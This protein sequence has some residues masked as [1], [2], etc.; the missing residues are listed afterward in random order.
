LIRDLGPGEEDLTAAQLIIIDRV[1]TK[2]GV[3]RCIEEHVRETSVMRGNDLAPALQKNYLAYNNS[4]RLD[5][6]ALGIETRQAREDLDL[7]RYVQAKDAE[8]LDREAKVGAERALAASA[9]GPEYAGKGIHLGE[10]AI[11][12]GEGEKR[13]S[14]MPAERRS[15][16]GEGRDQG[17]R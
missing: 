10:S 12:R 4:V 11:S 2:L 14:R 1:V 7:D 13:P 6:Q 3:I 15:P 16:E 9:D 5:L 17:E 8:K